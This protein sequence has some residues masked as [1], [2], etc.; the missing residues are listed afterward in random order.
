MCTQPMGHPA[1]ESLRI[2][3]LSANI[4]PLIFSPSG[5]LESWKLLVGSP[6]SQLRT[7]MFTEVPI[8]WY[9]CIT[10]VWTVVL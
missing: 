8:S 1:Q 6:L 5:K 2:R 7:L 3:Y 9:F 10:S 4:S